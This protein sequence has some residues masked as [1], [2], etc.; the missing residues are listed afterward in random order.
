MHH[1]H[2]CSVRPSGHLLPQAIHRSA[3]VQSG[4]L[5]PNG[6]LIIVGDVHGCHEELV[7]LLATVEYRPGFDNVLFVG[8]LVN[9]GPDSPGVLDTFI[10][11]NSLGVRGNHDDSV[12]STWHGLKRGQPAYPGKE[13]V[14]ELQ[15][16]HVKVL[17]D[18]P[19]TL[20]LPEYG[21]ILVGALSS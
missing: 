17:D 12:L 18:L 5:H 3:T 6:R 2:H 16:R 9:K 13:W 8:D 7:R 4:Q 14:S 1:A 19:F 11:L 21:I 10:K 20:S 15:P